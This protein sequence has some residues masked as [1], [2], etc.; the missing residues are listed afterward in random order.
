MQIHNV[1]QPKVIAVTADSSCLELASVLSDGRI[2][3]VPVIS[4]EGALIGIV[5]RTDLMRKYTEVL[6]DASDTPRERLAALEVQEI[7]TPDVVTVDP[8]QDLGRSRIR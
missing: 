2:S 4:A 5:S 8:E 3:G 6:N 1:M 7:M